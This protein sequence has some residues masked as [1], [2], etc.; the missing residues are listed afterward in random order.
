MGLTAPQIP[1]RRGQD[2]EH[3]ENF[4]KTHVLI[5][6]GESDERRQLVD[7]LS[8]HAADVAEVGDA[9]QVWP[10]VRRRPVD[11]VVATTDALEEEPGTLVSGVKQFDDS[12]EVVAIVDAPERGHGALEQGAYDFLLSPID[13]PRL[14]V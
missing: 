5:V 7:F 9:A 8:N 12:I 10:F 4:D 14:G 2:V 11:V 1:R 13:F 3:M 6:G